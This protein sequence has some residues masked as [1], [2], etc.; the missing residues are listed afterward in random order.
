MKFLVVDDET[1]A[2]RGLV[3]TLKRLYPDAEIISSQDPLMASMMFENDV[4]V[5][6]LDIE[7]PDMSGIELGMELRA[8]KENLNIIFVTAFEQYALSAYQFHASGYLTKPTSDQ[9]IIQE[10]KNLRYP[11]EQKEEVSSKKLQV[12]CFGNFE[13]YYEGA[14]V[15]F[16]RSGSKA[17]F[18]YLVDRNGA[19]VS[20]DELCA[21]FW[22]DAA[23]L[24]KKKGNIRTMIKSLRQT[25]KNYHLEEV[26]FSRRNSYAI[27]TDLL[28]CDYY[29]FLADPDENGQLF[30]GEYMSQYS[31]A[32]RTLGNITDMG[33]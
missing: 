11:L 26:L 30:R 29:K 5:A 19:S 31:W 23:D 9:Q 3:R 10:M 20:V 2:L 25:L 12:K 32:E 14:P 33:W 16:Q 15:H 1:I 17:I 7:M 21:S 4:D 8:K 13:V 27:N 6:F 22:D 28:D 24:D 18:A